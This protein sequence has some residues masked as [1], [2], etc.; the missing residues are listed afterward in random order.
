MGP[1]PQCHPMSHPINF[2]VG[3]VRSQ[4]GA[5]TSFDRNDPDHI[6]NAMDQLQML[7]DCQLINNQGR[8]V[9][10]FNSLGNIRLELLMG[11]VGVGVAVGSGGLSPESSVHSL[12]QGETFTFGNDGLD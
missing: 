10:V 7:V 4:I 8:V 1:C 9:E 6:N 11:N 2:H 12:D 3:A 5:D